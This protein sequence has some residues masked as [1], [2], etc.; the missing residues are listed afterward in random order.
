MY[1]VVIPVLNEVGNIP[2]LIRKLGKGPS[3]LLF[4]DNGSTDGS[5]LLIESLMK[6]DPRIKLSVGTGTVTAA[7]YRGIRESSFSKIVVMDGDLSHPPELVSDIALALDQYDMVLGS[8]YKNG[9][10][11]KDS[12]LNQF[13]SK[14]LTILTMPLAPGIKDR[15]TGFFG[16]R[17]NLVLNP[18]RSACKPALEILVRD[19][20]V[21]V[22]EV[23]YSF[24]ERHSGVSKIGRGWATVGTAKDLVFLYA[25]KYRKILKYAFVGAMGTSIY[26]GLLALFTEVF[27]IWYIISAI[28]GTG[29]AFVFNYTLNNLWTFSSRPQKA[30]DPD[31]EY[32]AWY[33][34]NLVQRTWKKRIARITLEAVKGSKST[35]DVG[36]GSSPLLALLP[37]EVTGLD[38]NEG[39]LAVQRVRC[40]KGTELLSYDLSSGIQPILGRHFD[41]VVCNNVL[42]HLEDPTDTLDWISD[43]LVPN[44]RLVITVPDSGKILTPLVERLYGRVMPKAYA[45]DHC[46][47]FTKESLDSM[48]EKY[49]LV[50]LERYNVFTDIVCVYKKGV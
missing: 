21:S 38:K 15:S 42:E 2:E 19:P 37:G 35:L 40:P 34:G 47:E 26:L 43:Y 12:V 41:S 25:S 8:R 49:N 16:I 39:K 10:T 36:C 24:K 18:L 4:C 5:Q 29:V 46:F 14:G 13:I 31:Y 32:F 22:K 48:C 27:H 44:G 1:T 9:G 50:L 30:A 3:E 33:K 11:T 23:P 17:R 45:A 28:I 20:V 6:S 7:V